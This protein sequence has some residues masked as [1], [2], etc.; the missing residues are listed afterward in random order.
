MTPSTG[1]TRALNAGPG[2]RSKRPELRYKAC[3]PEKGGVNFNLRL[4][5]RAAL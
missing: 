4:P 2:S 3:A 5:A 1:V